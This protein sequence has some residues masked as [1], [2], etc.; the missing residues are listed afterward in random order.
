[1]RGPFLTFV[2]YIIGIYA[3][4]ILVYSRVQRLMGF[5]NWKFTSLLRVLR[6]F[7]FFPRKLYNSLFYIRADMDFGIPIKLFFSTTELKIE[8]DS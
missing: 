6:K 2:K 1:M 7:A 4:N 3:V 8:K 5:C